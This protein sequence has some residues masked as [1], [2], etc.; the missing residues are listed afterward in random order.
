LRCAACDC[1]AIAT[2]AQIDIARASVLGSSDAPTELA[3]S[4]IRSEEIWS[5]AL[6]FLIWLGIWIGI[7]A[8]WRTESHFVALMTGFAA[9][10]GSGFIWRAKRNGRTVSQAEAE[11]EVDTA[12]KKRETL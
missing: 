12:T 2:K 8:M 11:A 4:S 6:S 9:L 5:V 3:D 7:H 1:P 10:L